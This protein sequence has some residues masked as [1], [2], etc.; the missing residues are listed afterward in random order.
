[1]EIKEI[2]RETPRPFGT[3][4]LRGESFPLNILLAKQ[5]R[6]SLNCIIFEGFQ[7]AKPLEYLDM[8]YVL[9]IV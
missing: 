5:D 3:P 8:A 1:M 7:G 4:L 2:S 6:I 9:Y